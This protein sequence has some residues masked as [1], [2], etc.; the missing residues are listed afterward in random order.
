MNGLGPWF[1]SQNYYQ[2]ELTCQTDSDYSF[3][4]E[5]LVVMRQMHDGEDHDRWQVGGQ[6]HAQEPPAQPDLDLNRPWAIR[7]VIGVKAGLL[8]VV[9]SQVL[10]AEVVQGAWECKDDS[11]SRLS[12]K[13]F[14][15]IHLKF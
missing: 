11:S 7:E 10:R 14:F 1:N 3:K 13:I 5:R 4:V 8:D 2:A 6:G 15:C 12:L 9:H